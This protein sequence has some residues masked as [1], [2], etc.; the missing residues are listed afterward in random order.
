MHDPPAVVVNPQWMHFP[1][2]YTRCTPVGLLIHVSPAIA[3]LPQYL[4]SGILKTPL[5]F[6]Y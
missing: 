1:G 4:H 6:P 2:T 3:A 5:E